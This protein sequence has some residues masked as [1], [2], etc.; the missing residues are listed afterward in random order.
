MDTGIIIPT[1]NGARYLT[2]MLRS[3][4]AQD[5]HYFRVIISDNG[6]SDNT[7]DIVENISGSLNYA[8]DIVDSSDK[9]GKAYAL[10]RGIA[11][12]AD[13]KK[14]LFLDQDDTVN[15]CYVSKMSDALD[16]HPFVAACMDANL[17]NSSIDVLPRYAP[18]DQKIGQFLIKIAAGGSLGA[19][20][21]MIYDTG[22]F[23]EEFNYSTN[24]V[25]FCV[26]AHYCGYELSLV[27]DAI[28]NYRF[29]ESW[30]DN[31]TQGLYYGEGNYAIAQ[32][33]PEIRGD[34]EDIIRLAMGA[35]IMLGRLILVKKERAKSAHNMGKY[36]GQIKSRMNALNNQ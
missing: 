20:W 4:D 10:N 25:E 15:S 11:H 6:S 21:D 26:R 34:Q 36:V 8:V 22:M 32:I 9:P 7:I 5:N 2:E 33:Y 17:L 28:L 13:T 27:K 18:R 24:D 31:Y 12:S 14:L 29:R 16:D 23:N 30:R 1:F 35:T 19:T 3:L